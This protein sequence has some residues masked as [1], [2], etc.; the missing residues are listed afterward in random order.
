MATVYNNSWSGSAG[1][2]VTSVTPTTGPQPY[3][4]FSGTLELN[5]SGRVRLLSGD[6]FAVCDLTSTAN[7]TQS[8][9]ASMTCPTANGEFVYVAF[10]ASSF[11]GGFGGTSYRVVFDNTSGTCTI[12]LR[13]DA[14]DLVSASATSGTTYSVLIT[15]NSSNT[16]NVYLNG[17]STAT[18]TYTDST[19][20]Y[21]SGTVGV[22]M[23]SFTVQSLFG[24][25]VITDTEDTPGGSADP[26]IAWSDKYV[27]DVPA[28]A[29]EWAGFGPEIHAQQ[30]YVALA[31]PAALTTAAVNY[32][33]YLTQFTQYDEYNEQAWLTQPL[34]APAIAAANPLYIGAAGQAAVYKS[35]TATTAKYL[36]PSSRTLF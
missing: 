28:T 36:G 7:T 5:G 26:G 19:S 31:Q 1:T 30:S 29:E 9:T 13:K 14:T 34:S 22:A 32:E 2:V 35:P 27:F 15:I 11:A 23:Q 20:P 3:N 10:R 25:L 24:T 16:I 33:N 17:S 6:T 8:L 12:V 21:T 18:L 4:L